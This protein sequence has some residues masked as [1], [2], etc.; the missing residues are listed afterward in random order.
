MKAFLFIGLIAQLVGGDVAEV[1]QQQAADDPLVQIEDAYK[2]IYQAAHGAEHLIADENAAFTRLQTEWDA[3]EIEADAPEELWTPLTADGRIGRL[4]LRPYKQGGGDIHAL[5][6]AVIAGTQQFDASEDRFQ[7]EWKILGQRLRKQAAGA[8]TYKEWQRL[9]RTMRT[10]QYPAIR[11]S[12]TYR[13]A[14]RPAYRVL[15]LEE[16]VRLCPA[17]KKE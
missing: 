3:L 17:L 4:N 11:H 16:A 8:L 13:T 10:K 12:E 14:R 15:P 2:W 9:D 6:R 1:V 5:H 7:K